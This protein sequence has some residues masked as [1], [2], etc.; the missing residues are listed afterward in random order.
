MPTVVGLGLAAALLLASA[1]PVRALCALPRFEL[2]VVSSLRDP[3]PS[4]AGIVVEIATSVRGDSFEAVAA[5]LDR[6]RLVGPDQ[7]PHVLVA[8]TITPEVVVLRPEAALPPG[9]Y[10]LRGTT[11]SEVEVT[12]VDQPLPAPPAAPR[13]RAL[14]DRTE[15]AGPIGTGRTLVAALVGDPPAG[16]RMLVASWQSADGEATSTAGHVGSPVA[17]ASVGRCAGHGRFPARG[18]RVTLQWLDA[19]GQRSAG[20][21]APGAR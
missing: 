15:R 19:F 9:V 17:L 6:A 21:V 20:S 12:L 7:T 10:A 8:E 2:R 4:A 18:A 16:A 13:I 3:R 14:R 11:E 5:R 1:S